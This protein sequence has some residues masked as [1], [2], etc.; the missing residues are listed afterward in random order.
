MRFFVIECTITDPN[1]IIPKNDR[2]D[3]EAV[4][5]REEQVSDIFTEYNQNATVKANYAISRIRDDTLTCGA[6]VDEEINNN[7]FSKF[8]KQVNISVKNISYK[9]TTFATVK[10]IFARAER[11]YDIDRFEIY[12]RYGIDN[13]AQTNYPGCVNYEERL[14]SKPQKEILYKSFDG[15]IDNADYLDELDRIYKGSKNKRAKGHPVHYIFS[16]D[17]KALQNLAFE[18]ILE[19]LYDNGRIKNQRYNIVELTS[20]EACKIRSF[21]QLYKSSMGGAIVLKCSGIDDVDSDVL[22]ANKHA[23][24]GVCEIASKYRNSVLT[25]ICFDLECIK[26]KKML[27]ENLPSMSFVEL[28]EAFGNGEKAQ[29]F[30]K[31]L[32]K[33]AGVTATKELLS[34]FMCDKK[35]RAFDVEQTF[36]LWFDDR[37]KNNIYSQYQEFTAL[38]NSIKN[39]KPTGTAYEELSN[40]IGLENAKSVIDRAIKAYKAQK[41]F[42]EKGMKSDNFSMHMSFTGNPGT[43][44]T[45]VARL[46]A[47]IMRD[48]GI[49]SI[50]HLVETGRADLVGKFVGWTAPTIKKKFEEAKGG[51]LF[52]DEAYSLLDRSGSFGDEAINTI[53]QEMENH[54]DDVI[55]IFAGYPNEMKEFI[56]K[57]PGLNS[58]IA[59]HVPFDDYNAQEL[60]EIS[61]YIATSKGLELEDEAL[62]KLNII[63]SVACQNNDFGNGRFARNIIEKAK[64]S[65]A[66]R[67]LSMDFDSVTSND[68]KIIKAE[69]I[70]TP[71]ELQKPKKITIGF[72][73]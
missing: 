20:E 29:N 53:V 35:Y 2:Y 9:E 37:L 45:T 13:I 4:S 43:A 38:R 49:L 69:D 57:N 8:F 36:N 34:K 1:L 27:L 26:M 65:Q 10:N 64:M 59:F 3:R 55:V 51:V 58:R 28:K 21:E 70:E 15:A 71:L 31:K 47:Q 7:Y 30:A 17:D 23:V 61:S 18:T 68:V 73:A 44:K 52:I 60:C 16:M 50:G 19:A 72:S 54:R 41:I 46:F 42:A 33:Q 66:S 32:A 24:S 48:N 40:M 62:E 5:S 11:C 67:L 14:I 6:I 22:T 12:D 25:I 63:F 56:A 39:K